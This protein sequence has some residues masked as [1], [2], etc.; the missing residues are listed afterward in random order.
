MLVVGSLWLVVFKQQATLNNKPK[1]TNR[2]VFH[3]C[4]EIF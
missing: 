2:D 4:L 1:T 3:F